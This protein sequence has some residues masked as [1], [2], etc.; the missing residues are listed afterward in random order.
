MGSYA[1]TSQTRCSRDIA[2]DDERDVAD[3]CEFLNSRRSLLDRYHHG[4]ITD[5]DVPDNL[6]H[7]YLGV[8][9]FFQ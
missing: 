6:G 7:R 5:P 1:K 2:S 4:N 9:A 8:K 3:F